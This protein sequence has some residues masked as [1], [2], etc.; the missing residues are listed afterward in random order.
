MGSSVPG[1]VYSLQVSDGEGLI[2][3]NGTISPSET[4]PEVV[5][6]EGTFVRIMISSLGESSYPIVFQ[7][8]ITQCTESKHV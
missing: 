7:G 3:Y 6:A 5:S 8:P 4:Y 1:C 2:S